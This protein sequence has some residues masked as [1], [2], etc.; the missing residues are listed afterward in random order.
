[1]GSDSLLHT[2]TPHT[3]PLSPSGPTDVVARPFLFSSGIKCYRGNL[4]SVPSPHLVLIPNV[5]LTMDWLFWAPNLQ[6][7][8]SLP[9]HTFASSLINHLLLHFFPPR[10]SSENTQKYTHMSFVQLVG[11][12][13]SNISILY[14]VLSQTTIN[15]KF[16]SQRFLWRQNRCFKISDSWYK[17][18]SGRQAFL[19][20]LWLIFILLF[21]MSVVTD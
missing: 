9:S 18:G 10:S 16:W 15:R 14:L 21:T 7:S 4:S 2:A 6:D 13:I 1:M 20:L 17:K 19:I 8:T 12:L 5:Q 3:S 11:V